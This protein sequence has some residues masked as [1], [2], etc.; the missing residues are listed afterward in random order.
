M[1]WQALCWYGKGYSTCWRPGTIAL[2]VVHAYHEGN[3]F[4]PIRMTQV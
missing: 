2:N 1:Q 3:L 4:T